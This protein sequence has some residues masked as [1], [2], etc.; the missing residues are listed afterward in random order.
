M[1]EGLKGQTRNLFLLFGGAILLCLGY[2][3]AMWKYYGDWHKG[4]DF[5]NSFGA[6][7]AIFSGLA[8][9]ALVFT[10]VLQYEGLRLAYK[11]LRNS[12]EA[13]KISGDALRLQIE[14]MRHALEQSRKKTEADLLMELV[15]MYRQA[16][17]KWAEFNGPA[18]DLSWDSFNAKYPTTREKYKSNEWKYLY[19]FAGFFEVCGILYKQ[20]YISDNFVKSLP[21]AKHFLDRTR[22]IVEGMRT[23]LKDPGLWGHWERFAEHQGELTASYF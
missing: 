19:D 17:Q 23:E 9:A 8:L 16:N 1:S 6:A 22:E 10:V 12:A 3:F 21:R 20:G 15:T 18:L 7:N 14:E 11:E 2:W 13:Q 5:G 4:A